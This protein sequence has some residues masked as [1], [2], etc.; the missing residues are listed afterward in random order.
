MPEDTSPT[1]AT[2]VTGSVGIVQDASESGKEF[3][4]DVLC[5]CPTL[6]FKVETLTVTPPEI[7]WYK[8]PLFFIII[9]D[10]QYLLITLIIS[11]FT[12][13]SL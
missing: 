2:M 13:S 11:Y 5:L 9:Y 8:M 3:N 10:F 4:K 6:S 7:F 1:L 12:V